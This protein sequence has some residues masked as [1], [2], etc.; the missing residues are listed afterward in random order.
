MPPLQFLLA[1]MLRLSCHRI[2]AATCGQPPHNLRASTKPSTHSCVH[3]VRS[4]SRGRLGRFADSWY[5]L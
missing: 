1:A 3:C 4:I 5:P 2:G